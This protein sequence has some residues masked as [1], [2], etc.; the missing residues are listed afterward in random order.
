MASDAIFVEDRLDVSHEVRNISY[1]FD[2][3]DLRRGALDCFDSVYVSRI[4]V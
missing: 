4:C 3:F 2:F 1:T